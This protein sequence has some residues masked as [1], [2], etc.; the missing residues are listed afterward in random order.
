VPPQVA[1][2]KRPHSSTAPGDV[3]QPPRLSLATAMPLH[4]WQSHLTPLLYCRDAVRLRRVCKALRGVM[5]ECPV[6]LRGVRL[7]QL[8]EALTCFPAAE[9]L[10]LGNHP[11][12][13]LEPAEQKKAEQLLRAFGGRLKHVQANQGWGMQILVSAIRAGAL[14]KL[15]FFKL[16]PRCSDQEQL[17]ADSFW[18]ACLSKRWRWRSGGVPRG[19]SSICSTSRSCEG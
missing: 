18:C 19:R 5:G 13:W 7:D 15:S 17:L 11:C 9:S 16:Y 10:G 3:K 1:G 4:V 6:K 8:E 14:P 2:D 12:W